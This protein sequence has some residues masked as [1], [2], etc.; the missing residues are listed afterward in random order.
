VRASLDCQVGSSVSRR[1]HRMT[2]VRIAVSFGRGLDD[3]ACGISC[4]Y[5]GT[6][7]PN[8]YA[9]AFT[10]EHPRFVTVHQRLLVSV[11]QNAPVVVCLADHRLTLCGDQGDTTQVTAARVGVIR[12]QGRPSTLKRFLFPRST[13]I[14][15]ECFDLVVVTSR[16]S[17]PPFEQD[18]S[19]TLR[20]GSSCSCT[21]YHSAP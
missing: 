2:F 5:Y 7:M 6:Q 21:L 16:Q 15:G 8:R 14:F 20:L 12:P 4:S 11:F 1:W 19:D 17:N 3:L 13:C 10:P 9:N 18:V